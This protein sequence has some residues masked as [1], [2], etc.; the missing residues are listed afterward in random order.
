MGRCYRQQSVGV[1]HGGGGGLRFLM[2]AFKVMC[3][4][5][6]CAQKQAQKYPDGKRWTR[7]NHEDYFTYR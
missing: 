7:M 5:C 1:Q 3:G 4:V 6:A 2:T